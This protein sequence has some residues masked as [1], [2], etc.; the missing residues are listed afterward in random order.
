MRLHHDVETQFASCTNRTA[1]LTGGSGRATQAN[2][3]NENLSQALVAI[4][5]A[6]LLLTTLQ[7]QQTRWELVRNHMTI[8]RVAIDLHHV[9]S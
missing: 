1:C 4:H 9:R 2:L 7:E 6:D 5:C 3:P 8:H